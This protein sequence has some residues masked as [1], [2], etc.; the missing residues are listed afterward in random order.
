MR[1]SVV[2]QES[3]PFLRAGKALLQGSVAK[4]WWVHVERGAHWLGTVTNS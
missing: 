1:P 3:V 2:N 4:A